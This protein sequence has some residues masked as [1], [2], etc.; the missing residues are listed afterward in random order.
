MNA[1][2]LVISAG[3]FYVLAYRFYGA[4]L[5][6][7]VAVLDD[8]RITPAYRLIDGKNYYPTN[9]WVLFGHHF[10][11]IAGA[12]PLIGPVL[13]AQFG[14]L[15]G[16]LWILI[17][18]TLAGGVHDFIILVASMRRDG[19]SIAQIA[20]EEVGTV[21]GVA[22]LAA[23]LFIL[24]VAIAGLGLAVINSLFHNPWG[25]FIIAMTIP[26]AILMGI[27]MKGIRPHKVTEISIIGF[28]LLVL[29]VILGRKILGSP[30]ASYFDF[31]KETLTLL[32]STY[33]FIASVLPVWLLLAPRDYL[34]SFMKIGVI[35]LLAAGVIVVAP[36]IKMPYITKFVHG[37]GPIIPGKIFPFVF[38]T[39]AC[40]AISGFH[41]LIS[42]GTTPKM[43]EKERYA[44]VIGYGA[45]L[46]EGFVAVMALISA[47]VLFPGDY[48]AINTKLPFA[49]IANLGFPVQSI[50]EISSMV[51]I[52]LAGRPGGAVSLAAGMAYIFGSIPFLKHL[53]AY[54]Y[55]FAL[56]FEALFILTTIDAGT[57]VAR[58]VVQEMG[59][60]FYK[61]FGNLRSLYGNII[62]SF[63]V[64]LSWGYFIYNGSISTIWPMFGTAN[65]LL[66]MLALCIGTTLIIKMGKVKYIWVTL[67]PMLFMASTTFTASVILI[68]NFLNQ[69]PNSTN[70]LSLKINCILIGM[71]LIL[72]I[73]IVIDSLIKW[74]SYII[75]KNPITSTEVVIYSFEKNGVKNGN[76]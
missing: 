74:Y 10:A 6:A 73:I 20:K 51:G 16:F 12:G 24:I 7:K 14:Y 57:R 55:Q 68:K 50:K 40:G 32:L 54:W 42:S 5:S 9:K 4:F 66:A 45:M 64:V 21:S 72:A 43:I 36:H 53:M 33:G 75:K 41:S 19:K 61:P 3:C 46:T 1:I 44:R 27:Y 70:P 11:A 28:S 58:Y 49:K 69:I 62:A 2:W 18:A 35:F 65:Q 26:I 31:G 25:T 71:M 23:I 47:S 60:Y 56:M 30:I 38:L 48:F 63:I 22:S 13:A 76:N 34:S 39:I 59:G 67:V 37:G 17:G 8:S 29:T 52:E 15:P